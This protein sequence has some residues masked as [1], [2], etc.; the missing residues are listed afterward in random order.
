MDQVV[1]T[2]RVPMVAA[3]METLVAGVLMAVGREMVVA[4]RETT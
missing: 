2:A 1:A 4:G 3:G